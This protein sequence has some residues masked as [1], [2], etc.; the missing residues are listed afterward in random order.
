MSRIPNV[1]RA[2]IDD[3]K[4]A[5]YLLATGHPFGRGKARFFFGL[6]FRRGE[7]DQLREALR[8][9]A[10]ANPVATSEETEFGSKYV[11]EGPLVAPD[12]REVGIRAVWFV[13]S[14]EEA[15]RFVTAYPWKG[16][17]K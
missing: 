3:R 10:A 5:D 7:I 11:V 6:G 4:L 2:V 9:H 16:G 1:E 8:D 15:P 12:G 14:G 17:V 13:E